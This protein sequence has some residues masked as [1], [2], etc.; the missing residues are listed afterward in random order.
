MLETHWS[1]AGIGAQTLHRRNS[2]RI[3]NGGVNPGNLND[4]LINTSTLNLDM[5]ASYRIDDNFTVTFDAINLS[6][7]P[8][9]QLADSIGRR[10]Y[11][12]HYTGTN[13]FA[14]LRY[15]Y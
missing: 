9:T 15:S 8:S 6:N 11:Y 3:P 14:G 5:A 12:N 1:F 4:F 10:L 13:F 7:Q 2:C